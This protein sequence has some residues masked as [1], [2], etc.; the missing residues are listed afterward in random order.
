MKPVFATL[1]ERGHIS[2]GY[3]DDSLLVGYSY[4][5]C[6]SNIVDTTT[7]LKNLGL[8]PHEDKSVTTPTQIIQH[9]G[10][11][12]NSIDMTVSLTREKIAT[13]TRLAQ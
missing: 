12:L 11:V 10:F 8:Y 3:L 1:R 6:Q 7:L 13:L 9:L 2:S 5:E 4:G